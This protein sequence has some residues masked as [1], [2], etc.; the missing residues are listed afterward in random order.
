MKNCPS[1]QFFH[2]KKGVIMSID[3]KC[4]CVKEP[5]GYIPIG[6]I[7]DKLDN[8][9]AHNE[10]EEVGEVLRYWEKEARLL[11][12][13]KGLLEILSEEIGYYRKVG[14]KTRG[15]H[16]VDEALTILSCAYNESSVNTATI[17]LNAATT[18]KAFGKAEEAMPYYAKAKE[19]YE[20]LLPQ[21]DFRLAGLYNNYATAL[22]DLEH[23]DEARENYLK[24]IKLLEAKED[25]F[26]EIAVSY[27]NLAHL[28]YDDAFKNGKDA[29]EKV[30][31]CLNK[32]YECLNNPRIKRDGNYAYICE[33][34]APAYEFFGYFLQKAEL[35]KRANDI[36]NAK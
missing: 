22:K 26:G 23:Y 11:Y 1:E 12:D 13:Q 8:L 31:E 30:D 4:C 21:D 10:M 3:E 16:A 15:L 2:L 20:R 36:Y 7:I 35:E 29:D 25:V 34:C 18:M 28:E 19:M 27:V 9:F 6:R 24:A 5:T 17:Y 32:A 14:D 33:K